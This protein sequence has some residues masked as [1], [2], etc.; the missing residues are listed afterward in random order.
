MK[1]RPT[2]SLRKSGTNFSNDTILRRNG[3]S[4]MGVPPPTLATSMRVECNLKKGNT[5]GV[6][7]PTMPISN[8]LPRRLALPSLFRKQVRWSITHRSPL[9]HLRVNTLS[10]YESGVCQTLHHSVPTSSTAASR[11]VH[12]RERLLFG[13]TTK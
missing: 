3:A 10:E 4:L 12:G 9:R 11:P 13:G 8:S 1:R 6:F 2:E 7:P 5:K